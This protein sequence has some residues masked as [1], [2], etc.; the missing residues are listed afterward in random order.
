MRRSG[1]A[2]GPPSFWRRG[3]DGSCR[4]TCG[5]DYRS[6]DA[7]AGCAGALCWFFFRQGTTFPEGP[8]GPGS[9]GVLR[10][11]S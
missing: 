4:P 3:D 11:R 8:C 1:S 10:S 6:R 7:D 9:I 2:G 5:R